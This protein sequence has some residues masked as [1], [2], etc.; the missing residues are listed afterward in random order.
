M[1]V[2]RGCDYGGAAWESRGVGTLLD[3]AHG[4]GS[5]KLYMY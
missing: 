2:E 3:P 4:P 1:G 5:M